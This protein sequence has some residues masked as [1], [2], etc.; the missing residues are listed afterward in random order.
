MGAAS[1]DTRRRID[2]RNQAIV[3]RMAGMTEVAVVVGSVSKATATTAARKG[4]RNATAERRS[5]IRATT[6]TVRMRQR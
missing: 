4:T 3:P 6:T 1:R 2:G 5:P